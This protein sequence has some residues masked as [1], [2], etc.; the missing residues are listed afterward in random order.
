MSVMSVVCD[1]LGCF[2]FSCSLMCISQRKGNRGSSS[3]TADFTDFVDE[4]HWSVLLLDTEPIIAPRR[5]GPRRRCPGPRN[6][7]LLAGV[8]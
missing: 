2:P 8:R 7:F 3:G 4:D 6:M 5:P 1:L